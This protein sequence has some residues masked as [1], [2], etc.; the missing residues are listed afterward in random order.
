M[1]AVGPADLAA[2][3]AREKSFATLVTPPAINPTQGELIMDLS[4]YKESGSRPTRGSVVG[5]RARGS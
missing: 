1:I 4:P 3:G 5:F 2:R